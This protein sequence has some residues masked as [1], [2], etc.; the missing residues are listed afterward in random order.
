MLDQFG[1]HYM[2]EFSGRRG[3]HVWITFDKLLTKELGYR[4]VCKLE[5][6][7]PALYGIVE[8]KEWG[9][10]R[11]P[12]TDSSR[13][14]IVGKQVKFPLSSHR[15]G[16]R[17]YFFTKSFQKKEDTESEKFLQEQLM[18]LE[19]YK[20]N[21]IEVVTS[22]LGIVISQIDDVKLK[23]RKYR[24]VDK[25]E[26]TVDQVVDILSET[27]VFKNIFLRMQQGLAM[28]QDWTVLLGTLYLCDSNAHYN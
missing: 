15:S 2:M 14:N 25:I 12:A 20:P 23:Y 1:F 10:D 9:L 6:C 4:I 3:I 8:S 27:E 11:F 26:I 28:P 18:I 22:R 19:D 21:D 24:L 17:S 13:N 7:C 16:K 5:K